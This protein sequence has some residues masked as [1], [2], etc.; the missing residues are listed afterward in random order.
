MNVKGVFFFY[1]SF[2]S[3]VLIGTVLIATV[4]IGTVFLWVIRHLGRRSR[5]KSPVIGEIEY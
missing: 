5:G 1:K 4:L 2:L 3:L